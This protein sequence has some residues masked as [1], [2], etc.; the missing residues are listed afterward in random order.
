MNV[1]YDER[2]TTVFF[3]GFNLVKLE[4]GLQNYVSYVF[5]LR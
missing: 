4:L 1:K 3:Y 5:G 2:G